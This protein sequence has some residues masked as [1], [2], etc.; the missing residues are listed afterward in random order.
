M[1]QSAKFLTFCLLPSHNTRHFTFNTLKI[2]LQA[3]YRHIWPRTARVRHKKYHLQLATICSPVSRML[4]P[5]LFEIEHQSSVRFEVFFFYACMSFLKIIICCPAMQKRLKQKN[6]DCRLD[7]GKCQLK[8]IQAVTIQ[9]N[10]KL[11]STVFFGIYG[12]ILA[13]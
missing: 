9:R 7:A 12:A 6:C 10:C 11:L 4:Q 1:L 5:L 3:Q 2:I 13:L 8:G